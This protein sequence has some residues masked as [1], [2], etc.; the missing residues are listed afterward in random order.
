M[1]NNVRMPL[2]IMS[3]MN[4]VNNEYNKNEKLN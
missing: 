3:T 1:N 4:N 2:A